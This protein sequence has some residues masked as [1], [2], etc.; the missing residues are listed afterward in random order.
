MGDEFRN[1]QGELGGQGGGGP[2]RIGHSL[3]HVGLENGD[4]FLQF[5]TGVN[6]IVPCPSLESVG[7]VASRYEI[8]ATAAFDLVGGGVAPDPVIARACNDIVDIEEGANEGRSH[9]RILPCESRQLDGRESGDQAEIGNGKTQIHIDVVGIGGEIQGVAAGWLDFGAQEGVDDGIFANDAVKGRAVFE[10]EG[11]V[12][13]SGKQLL[14]VG[15][16]AEVIGAVGHRNRTVAVMDGE[17]E[18]RR[19]PG[20]IEGIPSVVGIF[21]DGIGTPAVLEL[22]NI[23]TAPPLEHVVAAPPVQDVVPPIPGEMIIVDCA[24]DVLDAHHGAEIL[25]HPLRRVDK[26]NGLIGRTADHLEHAFAADHGVDVIDTRGAGGGAVVQVHSDIRLVFRIVQGIGSARTAVDGPV[27]SR[28]IFENEGII[29]AAA[30]QMA[31]GKGVI[32]GAGVRY[33]CQ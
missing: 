6:D 15:D 4:Q 12:P 27:E 18:V 28:R 14:D 1:A 20:E 16:P 33:E 11:V 17:G 30:H 29:A 24:G 23:E 19:D 26:G 21:H 31:E 7:A 9:R 3:H 25:D 22:V 32:K 5:E 13:L 2:H 10:H 8:F